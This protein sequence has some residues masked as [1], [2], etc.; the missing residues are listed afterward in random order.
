MRST[1]K[2]DKCEEYIQLE[3]KLQDSAAAAA[4]WVSTLLYLDDIQTHVNDMFSTGAVVSG[5]GVALKGIA[6]VT[7]VQVV[8]PQ[9]IMAS[10]EE[11]EQKGRRV[12]GRRRGGCKYTV[13]RQRATISSIP[14]G[15]L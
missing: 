5:S 1:K 11:G 12:R 10:P 8:V 9:V 7:T 6:E 15:T 14:Y 13:E 3:T 2:A 4:R